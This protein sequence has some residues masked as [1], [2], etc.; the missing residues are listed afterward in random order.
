MSNI[1]NYKIQ[2]ESFYGKEC[3]VSIPSGNFY[4]VDDDVFGKS[5]RI[6][7]TLAIVK[8]DHYG[9]VSIYIQGRTNVGIECWNLYMNGDQSTNTARKVYFEDELDKAIALCERLNKRQRTKV[10]KLV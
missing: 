5:Y 1:I 6:Y 2:S 9:R 3:E 7:E 8:L 10:K 4:Y